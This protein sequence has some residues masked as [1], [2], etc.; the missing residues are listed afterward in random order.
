M[1]VTNVS[2]PGNLEMV[3]KNPQVPLQGKAIVAQLKLILDEELISRLPELK[4]DLLKI[5][6]E[7]TPV[8]VSAALAGDYKLRGE[9]VAQLELIADIGLIRGNAAAIATIKRVAGLALGILS[10][11]I[12]AGLRGVTG[13]LV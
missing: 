12:A 11:G 8:L 6:N 13:G 3:P 7:I 5:T 4:E 1:A 10:T 9:L 2:R